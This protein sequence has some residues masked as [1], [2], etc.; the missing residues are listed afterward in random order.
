MSE[1]TERQSMEMNEDVDISE[2][3]SVPPAIN[4]DTPEPEPRSRGSIG[5]NVKPKRYDGSTNWNGFIR[6]FNRVHRVNRWPE[7]SKL[8]YLMVLLEGEA[9]AYADELPEEVTLDYERLCQALDERFGDCLSTQVHRAEL[10]T[11]MRKVDESLPSLA[12]DIRRLVCLGYPHLDVASCEELIMD[13]FINAVDDREIRMALHQTQPEDVWE[14]VKLGVDLEA[15]KMAEARGRQKHI[16]ATQVATE[17]VSQVETRTQNMMSELQK[18]T[19]EWK[20]FTLKKACY[21]CNSTEHL[22][23]DCTQRRNTAGK[24]NLPR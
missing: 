3:T 9:A 2:G 21:G 17:S 11:R 13:H 20:D 1:E 16:R 15:W 10:K 4:V 12:Q 23:K 7:E 18:L 19:G 6:H 24:E 8:V 22:I 14:A 5:M